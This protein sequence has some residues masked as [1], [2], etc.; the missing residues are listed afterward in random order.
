MASPNT[1]ALAAK[2]AKPVGP[3]MLKGKEGYWPQEAA[4]IKRGKYEIKK[5][6]RKAKT[7]RIGGRI[8][9]KASGY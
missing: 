2:R 5:E 1:K 8:I 7:R 9:P 4:E 3:R 6:E